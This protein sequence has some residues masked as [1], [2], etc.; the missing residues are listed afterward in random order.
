MLTFD[1]TRERAEGRVRIRAYKTLRAVYLITAQTIEN[2]GSR[3]AEVQIS[4]IVTRQ[5]FIDLLSSIYESEGATFYLWQQNEFRKYQKDFVRNDFEAGFFSQIWKQIMGRIMSSPNLLFRVQGMAEKT[6]DDLRAVISL[7]V[8][9]GYGARKIAQLIRNRTQVL[10]KRA[11]VIART[12][13][14]LAASLGQKEAAKN[15]TLPLVK[16]WV[17][18]KDERTRESHFEANNQ[19]VE[20]EGFF[21][22]GGYQMEFP[23]DASAPAKEVVNCRCSVAYVVD[24]GRIL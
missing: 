23:G 6:K 4:N 10:R 12:E 1:T 21:S 8:Q 9:E 5:L 18:A 7:G 15:S 13:T 22:V 3:A 14:T 17:S 19:K 24:E 2:Q 11:V 20:K 16:V